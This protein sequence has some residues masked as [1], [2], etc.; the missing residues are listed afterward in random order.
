MGT[1]G[2]G[3]DLPSGAES[4]VTSLRGVNSTEE[5]ASSASVAV[6]TWS[7]TI[8]GA[9]SG[10]VYVETG[11]SSAGNSGN[12]L[13]RT[14]TASGTRG[15]IGMDA[16]YV[17]APQGTSDPTAPAGSVY[18]NTST[19]KLRLYDGSSWVSLN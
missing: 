4:D 18:Y 6:Y 3:P 15:Y 7:D 19:N 14:G 2:R 11:N 13:M 9:N 1:V 17:K 16:L 5:T 10:H 8:N 12:I